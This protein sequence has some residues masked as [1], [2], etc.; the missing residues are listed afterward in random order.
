MMR[1]GRSVPASWWMRVSLRFPR[2]C[3]IM[4]TAAVCWATVVSLLADQPTGKTIAWRAQQNQRWRVR[5]THRMKT[6]LQVGEKVTAVSIL[7]AMELHWRVVHIDA[8]GAMH[9]D[10]SIERLILRTTEADGRTLSYDSASPDAASPELGEVADTLRP[11][12]RSRVTLTLSPRGA[13]QDVQRDGET[14]S[15]L[16]DLPEFARWRNLLTRDGIHRMLHRALGLLP[17]QPVA[18]GDVWEDNQQLETPL[19]P[20]T[21]A[22]RFEYRGGVVEDGRPLDV[23]H[24]TTTIRRGEPP[25]GA[26]D[27][28]PRQEPQQETG[29][30][31][32][33]TAAGRLVRSQNQHLWKSEVPLNEGRLLVASSG[34]LET[35]IEPLDGR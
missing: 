19:G 1:I 6:E 11:L 31:H 10:Q 26:L 16:R 18:V 27:D 30:F 23:I 13:I 33:D 12:L 4:L 5:M 28:P 29:T 34:V 22:D 21:L 8:E 2:S 20:M 24:R 3:R 25:F 9:I 14:E 15:L 17:D 7:S 35:Q 32:F